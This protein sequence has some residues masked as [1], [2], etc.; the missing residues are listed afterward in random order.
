MAN[1]ISDG[2]TT[3]T[4]TVIDGYRATTQ[5]NNIVRQVIGASEPAVSFRT[6]GLRSGA[7]V[8]VFSD[9]DDAHDLF[10]LLLEG[11][12]LTLSS[13][14]RPEISMDFVS[15]EAIDIALDDLTRSVWLVTFDWQEV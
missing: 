10:A 9:S 14:D 7:M 4:P 6:A 15:V 11:S 5:S 3:V 13:S 12:A 2:V 1:T 8:C